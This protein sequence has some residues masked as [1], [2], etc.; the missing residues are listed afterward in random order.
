M[1]RSLI[2][3]PLLLAFAAQLQRSG[4][5]DD[6]A[7]RDPPKVSPPSDLSVLLLSDGS[8]PSVRE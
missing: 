6:L 3:P 2:G 8:T 5:K 7:R 1:V 4:E